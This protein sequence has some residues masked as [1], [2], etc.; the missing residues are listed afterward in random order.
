M[1]RYTPP[2]GDHP[3]TIITYRRVAAKTVPS[4]F[5][6]SC[7]ATE[8]NPGVR[9]PLVSAIASAFGD[10]VTRMSGSM[11]EWFAAVADHKLIVSPTGHGLDTHRTWEILTLGRIPIVESSLLD[12]LYEG[13][14]VLILGSWAELARPDEV[15]RRYA[16]IAADISAGEYTSARVWLT[17]YICEIFGAA[18]RGHEHGC[19]NVAPSVKTLAP[20][21]RR[22]KQL[23]S[24]ALVPASNARFLRNTQNI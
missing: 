5:L 19:P 4:R 6:L 21:P 15:E 14:P 3:E 7:F 2:V 9:V 1:N 8:T 13:L 10:K 12:P 18:G 20:L 11:E 23:D 17:Y 24:R 16:E 22:A